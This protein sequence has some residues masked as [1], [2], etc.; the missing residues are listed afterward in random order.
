MCVHIF[1]PWFPA[2]KLKSLQNA[3]GLI[4]VLNVT[5]TVQCWHAVWVFL[6]RSYWRHFTRETVRQGTFL[7]A[8]LIFTVIHNTSKHF[9]GH[10]FHALI[11]VVWLRGL[12]V[13]RSGVMRKVSS[14]ILGATTFPHSRCS[15]PQGSIPFLFHSLL[16]L[17]GKL[18]AYV[19]WYRFILGGNDGHHIRLRISFL[20]KEIYFGGMSLRSVSIGWRK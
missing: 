9:F 18:T 17:Q 12:M 20:P 2:K 14:S 10:A 15:S 16:R 6:I 5:S 8:H 13:C 7:V 11:A 1:S 4:D 3:T 19:C